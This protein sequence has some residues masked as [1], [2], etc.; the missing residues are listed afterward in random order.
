M[1]L[2]HAFNC[3]LIAPLAI[4]AARV[5]KKARPRSEAYIY[6]YARPVILVLQIARNTIA[7]REKLG[8]FNE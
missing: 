7:S 6:M 8:L 4:Q 3:Q 2:L 5:G 1:S